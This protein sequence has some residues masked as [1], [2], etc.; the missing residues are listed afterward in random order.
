MPET[1]AV[2]D[3]SAAYSLLNLIQGSVITQAISVAA[4]LGIADVLRDG[5]LPAEDIAKRVGADPEATYRLLRTLSGYSVFAVQSDGR[6]GLT[7]MAD[8]LRDDAPDSMRGIAT[9]M[10]HPLLWED[11]GN[12]L[13][14]VRSGEANMPRLRGM[15]AY[16]FLT[17]NPEYAAEFFQ[18]M[19]SMSEPETDPVLAAYDFSQFRT[20]VDVVGGRGGLLAGILKQ[21]SSARG[22][23]YDSEAA[24]AD[25]PAVFDAAGVGE[26]VTIENGSFFDKLPA[27]ADA[28]VLKHI[29]H[30]FTEPDCLTVLR[31]VREAIAPDGTMLV[32][33][34]V[35]DGNNEHHIGNIIDLWLLLLL[36]AKERTLP[37]Y[38]E[39]FAKAGLHVVRAVPT[40]S[41][42]SI[43]EAVPDSSPASETGPGTP[44]GS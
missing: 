40:A 8:A 23:L 15:G 37:Q 33:E 28:Y 4:R 18:G 10:S 12:L 43:I 17:A 30:D 31:N 29:L 9:L 41:P 2:R 38:S 36:G 27:G 44:T 21:A 25:A 34:Y 14:S 32:I 13:E 39:L 7:P 6:F 42:V 35:L 5:P 19:R 16:E 26:R 22:I 11:W 24:T 1:L 3:Q 20:I